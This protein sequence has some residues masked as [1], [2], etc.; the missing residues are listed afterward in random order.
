MRQSLSHA[1][2]LV[3]IVAAVLLTSCGKISEKVAE[4]AAEKAITSSGADNADVDVS[5][6]GISISGEDDDGT[7]SM[8]AGTKAKIPEGFPSDVYV[9]DG[10]EV[11]MVMDNPAGFTISLRCD[12]PV[13]DVVETYRKQ[14]SA[15]GW[16]KQTYMDTGDS[17][18]LIYGKGDRVLQVHVADDEGVT[19][20]GLSAAK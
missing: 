19:R 20:I 1:L 16:K 13:G 18:M 11:E 5:E 3:M 7:F 8:T 4:E 9:Y 2:V 15:A 12:D 10:A 6:E 14:L 17:Q